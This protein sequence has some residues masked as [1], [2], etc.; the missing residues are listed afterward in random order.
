[1]SSES[2]NKKLCVLGVVRNASGID[3]AEEMLEWLTPLYDV[4]VV[5]HDGT[6]FEYPALSYAQELATDTGL[7]VLYLHTKGAFN[8]PEL[9]RDVREMWRHEFTEKRDVYFGLVARP[10]AAVACPFTGSDKTTWYNGFVANCRA[11]AEI[12][13]IA[14]STNRMKYER[15][16]IGQS[17][18]VIGVLRNDIHRENGH[19]DERF[20]EYW[21]LIKK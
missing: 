1:M 9:S 15:L 18:Q 3:I 13:A 17:P 2:I 20:E 19:V 10:F 8:R 5:H 11:F 6:K 12:P 21:K 7:P 16:F 4:H 14:P